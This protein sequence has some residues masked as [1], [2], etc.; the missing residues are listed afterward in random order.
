MDDL[1]P[2]L[3]RRGTRSGRAFA[4]RLLAMAGW[5]FEG[6]LPNVPRAVIA[7][8]PHTS[9]WDLVV[10]ATGMFALG[11][12]VSF[13]AKK[14]L[15]WWPLSSLLRWLG[16]LEVDRSRSQ[17]VVT[18]MTTAFRTREQ[19]L[20]AVA[21]EGTRGPVERWRTGFYHIARS[22]GVPIVPIFLDYRTRVIG[23]GAPLAPTGRLEEDLL[24]LREFIAGATGLRDS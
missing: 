21:P 8:V 17:G 2:A 1:A 15:F 12:R 4:R 7:V 18:Q 23:I 22:A 19:L 6:S 3:P 16:A 5:R 13:L 24:A 11:V 9:N 14:T 10:G 20:L